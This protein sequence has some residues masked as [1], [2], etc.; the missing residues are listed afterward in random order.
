MTKKDLQKAIEQADNFKQRYQ[1]WAEKGDKDINV[2]ALQ[3]LINLAK[4]VVEMDLEMG[5]KGFEITND[6]EEKMRWV[7]PSANYQ[8]IYVINPFIAERLFEAINKLLMGE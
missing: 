5:I 6:E 4:R 1:E 8:Q 3:D 2:K 7:R